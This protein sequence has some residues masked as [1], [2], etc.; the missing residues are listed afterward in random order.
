MRGRSMLI[1]DDEKDDDDVDN[2]EEPS[3]SMNAI[4]Y[5]QVQK[6]APSN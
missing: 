6:Y 1:E 4:T 5:I 2:D 3:L